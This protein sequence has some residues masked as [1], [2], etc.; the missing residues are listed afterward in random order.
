MLE[1]IPLE[2]R[3]TDILEKAQRG[4]KLDDDALAKNAGL[5]PDRVRSLKEKGGSEA[6]LRRIATSLN[7]N[8]DALVAI[9]LE[10][11][12]PRPCSLTGVAGFNTPFD[13]MT[14]NSFLAWDPLTRQAIAF[15]TG[16]DADGMIAHIRSEDLQVVA[17]LL[18]HSHGD[19]IYDLDR[20]KSKTG[21]PAWIGENEPVDGA[22][23]FSVGKLFEAGGL[24]I[25]TRSTWGHSK[26][27]V[28]YII[29]GLQQPIAIVGDAIFAG[30]M[31]GGRVS[32]ADALRT[33]REALMSLPDNAIVCPGHG[34]V[35]TIGEERIHNPFL[36]S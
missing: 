3:F 19:H 20:L 2:D 33:N 17:I 28:S 26:G 29:H 6:D 4:L 31:G 24:K 8:P 30:S 15:D 36:A 14:V 1:H 16:A 9:A 12:R 34:P 22:Q 11:W 10:S 23:G 18:T 13:D 25:E 5:T 35:T 21:A 32:Y 7:L 27:G